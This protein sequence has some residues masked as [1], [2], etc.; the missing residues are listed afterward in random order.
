MTTLKVYDSVNKDRLLGTMEVPERIQGRIFCV[1]VMRPA[2]LSEYVVLTRPIP[3][4]ADIIIFHL[5]RRQQSKRHQ[6]SFYTSHI[7]TDEWSVLE[8]KAPLEVL[9]DVKGFRLPGETSSEAVRPHHE[10]LY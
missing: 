1:T 8:T 6:T 2:S 9:M 7:L 3:D 10:S 4:S 5:D